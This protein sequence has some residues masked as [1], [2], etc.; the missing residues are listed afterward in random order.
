MRRAQILVLVNIHTEM[1]TRIRVGRQIIL[2]INHGNQAISGKI[3]T[4]QAP[5]KVSPN[6]KREN[7]AGCFSYAAFSSLW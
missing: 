3:K 6:L 1:V 2:A 5:T 4:V 7:P